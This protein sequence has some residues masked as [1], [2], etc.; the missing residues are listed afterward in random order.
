M[1]KTSKLKRGLCL[2]LSLVMLLGYLP[3]NH[4]HAASNVDGGLEGQ[5][6]DV[7]TALGFDTTVLPDGYN[8]ETV[9]NPYGRDKLAGNQVFEMVVAGSD[10]ISRAGQGDNNLNV[11]DVV[12][13]GL[14]GN[15]P[16]SQ[17][18][19]AAGDFDGDGLPGEVVY[20]GVQD[21]KLS[22][23][24]SAL[25]LLMVTYD[26]KTHTFNGSKTLGSVSITSPAASISNI[27][28]DYD[29]QNNLQVTTGDYDG[30]GYA[31]I[32]VYVPD[33]GNARVDV[34][35]WMRDDKS[36]ATDWKEPGNWSV[37]WS[38][39][40]SNST[41][42]DYIPNMVSLLSSDINRDGIDD[43]AVASSNLRHIST[44]SFSYLSA[45]SA[46]IL[47]GSR[48]DMLRSRTA[49]DLQESSLGKQTR[50][51][52]TMGDI[53]LDGY[54]E[55]VVTGQPIF[56]ITDPDYGATAFNTTRGVIVYMYGQ[57]GLTSLYSGLV[58]PLDGAYEVSESEDESGTTTETKS[59]VSNNG[60]D[61]VYNSMPYMRTNAAVLKLEG[62]EYGYLYLDS[63]LYEFNEGT[64]LLKMSLDDAS[65]DGSN[66]LED[67]WISNEKYAEYG[68]VAADINGDGYDQL[69]V[70]FYRESSHGL[71]AFGT[72]DAVTEG[73]QN[74]YG[75]YS[76]LQGDGSGGLMVE[77]TEKSEVHSYTAGNVVEQ[78]P[79]YSIVP[80]DTD[81]DTTLIV[82]TGV[83]NLT[84]S[85][86][87]VL[88]IIAAAPY[89]EDV[90]VISDYDYAWRNTTSFATIKGEGDSDLV[91]VDLKAGAY[92]AY[93]SNTLG[94]ATETETSINF[95]MD[96]EHEVA[97][98]T[99]YTISY[100][101]SQDQDSVVM[102]SVPM[103]NYLYY[104]YTPDENGVYQ[105][106]VELI[107]RVFQPVTQ[108]VTLDYYES[109]RKDFGDA[110]P[111]IA[112]MAITSTPGDPGSYPSS[113]SG[114][115]VIN[116]WNSDPAGISFGNGAITQEITYTEENIESYKFGGALDFKLGAGAHVEAG[117][118][119]A[120]TEH[121]V[122]G[123]IQF[124]LN[125]S[126]GYATL[127]L[128]GTT[129]SGTVANM[130]LKFQDY[131]YYYNW[132]LFSYRYNVGES[133]IPVI[134]YIVNDVS[135]PPRLP[136]D[137]QQ[138]V[139]RTTSDKNVLTWSYDS[140]YS[141][142]I[143]H[144]Y[145]DFPVGGGLQEIARYEAGETPYV[146]KYDEGGNPYREY[147][148]EDTN[149]APYTEY[150]YAI[151]VKRSGIPPSSAPSALLTARTKAAVGNPVITITESDGTDNGNLLVY[152]DRD[153]ELTAAVTGPGGESTYD[154]YSTVQYQ[155]QKKEDG[156]WVDQTNKTGEVLAFE[157]A[158]EKTAGEYRCRVNVLTKADNTA[159]SSYSAPVTVQQSK[160]STAFEE[161]YVREVKG[162][163][164][165]Y[166]KV[167][168][169]HADSGAVPSGK[170]IFNMYHVLTG[171]NYQYT[172]T[173]DST[174]A[175]VEI[176]ESTLPAG[177]YNVEV[178][179][180]GSFIFK[181]CSGE[182]VFL[183]QVDKGYTIDAPESVVYGD[184]AEMVFNEVTINNGVS[185]NT[186]VDAK[187]IGVNIKIITENS[188][189]ADE[190]GP[191]G[192]EAKSGSEVV[193][194]KLYYH[195][196]DD[197]YVALGYCTK[198][199]TF[200]PTIS[201][202]FYL[203]DTDSNFAPET[204]IYTSDFI[205]KTD[206][207][208]VYRLKEDTP[209]DTYVFM[210]T[211][212]D[213]TVVE[214]S[215]TVD[216]RAITLQ[217]PTVV[218][219]QD[220]SQTMGSITYGELDV[221]SGT[222]ANC[223]SDQEGN[224]SG[225]IG[226]KSVGYLSYINSAG[227]VY[228]ESSILDTCGFY[229]ISAQDNLANYNVTF[230]AGSLSVIG[231]TKSVTFSVRPFEGKDVGTL[232]M[233]SPDYAYTREEEG[234]TLDEA[235]GSRL[236]FS[237]VP[238]E[239]Y[240]IYDWYV[241]GE[242]Q[243]ITDTSLAY[244]MLNRDAT[245]E[246]QF[247]F[248]PD[249]LVF[250]IAG[251]TEGG[252]LACSDTGLT[253]G[254]IV[255]PN[256]YLN[257]S[258][259][260][261][262]DYHFKEWRYTELGKGTAYYD[263][264][265][266]KM[267]SFFELLMPKN[268]CSLY[269]VFERDGYTFTYT[270]KNGADGLTAWYWGSTTGD[271]TAGLEKITVNSG[272]TVPG[273][274]QIVV[275]AKEGFQL[276]EDYN[277]VATGSQGVADYDAG[278]YT[279]TLTEDT[280]VT[281]Y[282]VRN[283]F[284]VTVKF[285]IAQTYTFPEG[286]QVTLT[287]DGEE[288]VYDCITGSE[289]YT[290]A[291]VDGGSTVSVKASY[292]GY[293]NFSGWD[294][295]GT[296]LSEE[297]HTVG[298]A[299]DSVFTL[300]LT[301]K[302]VYTV[303][304][305][306]IAGKG[307]Y[308]VTMPE[309]AGQDGSVVTCHENDPLT[310][311]VTPENGYTVT[312]WNVTAANE[313][314]SWEAKASSLKYQFPILTANYTFTPVF[315][316]TTY[317]LVSWPTLT[318]YGVTLTP[319]EGYLTTVS[320]GSDFKFTLSGGEDEYAYVVVNGRRFYSAET[321]GS[322]WPYRYETVDGVTEY[323]ISNI[324]GDQVISVSM[325]AP[326]YGVN[327]IPETAEVPAGK[328]ITLTAQPYGDLDITVY[329][330]SCDGT[331]LQQSADNTFVYQAPLTPGE[332][333]SILV[334]GGNM[335]NGAS[336]A[337]VSKYAKITI[338][339]VVESIHVTTQDL[340]TSEDGSYQIHPLTSTGEAGTYDFDAS[341][342]MLS[343]ETSTNVTWS[344][345]GAQMRG[346]TVEADGVLTVSPKEYG[347]RGQLKLIATYTYANGDSDK[348]ELIINLLPDAY[349]ACE[350][351]NDIHGT[352]CE[353]IGHVPAGE[354]VTVT[355]QP[356][357]NHAVACWYINGVAVSGETSNT[358][359]FTAEEMTH[360]VISV[361]F[362]HY[363]PVLE[364][365]ETYHGYGKCSCGAETEKEEHCDFD[366]DHNCD[367]CDYVLSGCTDE[368]KDHNC[369]WCGE[370]A[371]ECADGD[372]DHLCD[373]CKKEL[374][375][376][377]DEDKNH[378][379]D[380][381]GKELS[382]CADEDKNHKC[383]ICGKEVSSCADEDK[384]HKCDVCNK[385]LST[386]ADE[387]K[388]H[389]C[390]V[391]NKELSTCADEDK[392]HNCDVCG[393][394]LSTCADE[395]TNHKCDV[396]DKELST[397]ADE[398]K[399]HKCDICGKEVSSCA[400][401]DRNH[402]CDTCGTVMSDHTYDEGSHIC[403]YCGAA[404]GECA[405]ENKDH[406]CD[407][408]GKELSSCTDGD[409]NH[410]CDVCGKE[411]SSCADED[412]NHKC[413]ICG[414]AVGDH[415]NGECSHICNY[416]GETVSE[417]ADADKDHKCDICGKE[418]STCTDEDRNHKCDVCG[419]V[420]T[421]CTDEDNNHVCDVCGAEINLHEDR[422]SDHNCDVCGKKLS[423]CIDADN[424]HLCDSC[425]DRISDCEDEDDHLCDLCGEIVSEC[426]D[427]DN[428][429]LCDI[430][431]KRLSQ[432][433]DDDNDHLCD[434]CAEEMHDC[435]DAD[436]D[437]ICDHC[438]IVLS[439]CMDENHD[440]LCDVCNKALEDCADS[441]ND[442]YC[443]C[444]GSKLS[445]CVDVDHNDLCDICGAGVWVHADNNSD[446]RCDVCAL[447]LS[448][449]T[450]SDKNHLC[451]VCGIVSSVCV[452]DDRNHKCDICGIAMGDHANGEN[453]HICDYCGV[454][455]SECADADK[456]NRCDVCGKIIRENA[457]GDVDRDGDVDEVDAIY[458]LWHT[459]YPEMY[460]VTIDADYDKDGAVTDADALI[461]LWHALFDTAL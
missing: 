337:H 314:E 461:L 107:S 145:F 23:N 198:Y 55:L 328:R 275:Q 445:D 365:D 30:D 364:Q 207:V 157:S 54:N 187:R 411:L 285:D 96:W 211:A 339:D 416:C 302:P 39:V 132:K 62:H 33:K 208:G 240:Q 367:V 6:A 97:R 362:T 51:S 17:F 71:C 14:S 457:D 50:V 230:R 435:E 368:D 363:Y 29:I 138:D 228:T 110:M 80:A 418:L 79:C 394:E 389:K 167:R 78:I 194:G 308:S 235:V 47:W 226:S 174:G 214:R 81:L 451:D 188:T 406:M 37:V 330:W 253:S 26:G 379:C 341:V 223:D 449:C 19:G 149:L 170:V 2:L 305:A 349:V 95:T 15:V 278:T 162:G 44:V 321:M 168:N 443:D 48:T 387:D 318:Y 56:D 460:P 421:T 1:E 75:G 329:T 202:T 94:F 442:H 345:W 409:K 117:M 313:S 428:D 163:I 90:D 325:E 404:V 380:V 35:K 359:T 431:R 420:L 137:F 401:E 106:K 279:L 320:S 447:I 378:K 150:Q 386:C 441:N 436:S 103:E 64:L 358:L 120:K 254:S 205:E 393:K 376:C 59:W 263:G 217:L 99:E 353:D 229:T 18:A 195:E 412:K 372:N 46:S 218:K 247:V 111:P 348:Q 119:F 101:T 347:T 399:N 423:E 184:G 189:I 427:G 115:D 260:A 336:Y 154:Y 63:C 375:T 307:S 248:K 361:E 136:M 77:T 456:D 429:H 351:V 234:A 317:H 283:A 45:A 68:A 370:T 108:V 121:N 204:Y 344:L 52:L 255:I 159:I 343:G 267:S 31:E 67:T 201:G 304:L 83:H 340:T 450:D 311:Q 237:A 288:H 438:G 36:K 92:V 296:N 151:Q 8:A 177:T 112:G 414:N 40:L 42:R 65:Y 206:R 352:I 415:V 130:P 233:V 152:P 252:T 131:G 34:Y 312:Y 5:E 105:G 342:S 213:G 12:G 192:I 155:W 241:N 291:N 135:K 422:N 444:C 147:Y 373:V 123:G 129:V 197:K 371:S 196:V 446:H 91:S 220:S 169:T 458:L 76:G 405:D 102:Y 398:D 219:K 143:L 294:L 32:A 185:V 200:T 434:V 385:E 144:K 140:E 122:T 156:A 432:C 395:D 179:Y 161:V 183:F 410:K 57:D 172:G 114:Y 125:P 113:S 73:K 301:E 374:S 277:F 276:D 319:K 413:D 13:I 24:C 257:F 127:N 210:A 43:L 299:Q 4:V 74:H 390:D 246:V 354:T 286:T 271:S 459:L 178:L 338:T 22:E 53:N 256:T 227:T 284:D 88:A 124:S 402:K 10:G 142:F 109:I 298:L 236:V 116:E 287:I 452:D 239:G 333:K 28:Y 310:I 203:E 186:P 21:Y 356:N 222:W 381:C 160:R 216:S 424:N 148:F 293:Y 322:S 282:T 300:K 377:S 326:D 238:D 265:N 49:I 70:S 355:A 104:V 193:A 158:G 289:H 175:Y 448:E 166:A 392:N 382:T 281:G 242:A 250:G 181:T 20:V 231:G 440:H 258:A 82:Y 251:A 403:N 437:H 3:V 244:A 7:F 259:K 41:D 332:T 266:G 134:S 274:T 164:E 261:Q 397:C 93:S 100:Q 27:S 133:S 334:Q 180:N 391:C 454:T 153:G 400:D 350:T 87:K 346:T 407:I 369:D 303:T 9:D 98:T 58:K 224:V 60:F 419:N 270:D 146:L 173:L 366:K 182:C 141:E 126:G 292:P 11:Y 433:V 316:D 331:Q 61:D 139:E 209:V 84:Y 425:A 128:E 232:Y 315:S 417:C 66:T 89:F 455:V 249:T 69:Y 85:D 335:D 426:A 357:E 190:I 268:S 280:E 191:V 430:C 243:G 118:G 384:N 245:V 295:N 212:D 360:Y 165:L 38:H 86:P 262:E 199:R 269:A 383:D 297:T 264:D 408:C 72:N 324:T 25:P 327:I 396:C 273:D 453:S 221:V 388:N 309:G 225:S 171:E 439:E 290:I 306:D 323:T 16:L 176:V 272:D 215:I